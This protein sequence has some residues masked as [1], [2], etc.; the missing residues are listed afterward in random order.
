[1]TLH[2]LKYSPEKL[3]GFIEE[4]HRRMQEDQ[5]FVGSQAF[6]KAINEFT[7]FLLSQA[8]AGTGPGFEALS[9]GDGILVINTDGICPGTS[10]STGFLLRDGVA[11]MYGP[12]PG[13]KRCP[14]CRY[15]ITGPAHLLGQVT[16]AN[17][18]AYSIRKKGLE[19]ARLNELKLDAED[20]GNQ[21]LARELRDRVDLLNREIELDVA[22]WTARYKYVVQSHAQMDDYLKEKAN[23]IA[24]DATPRVP[25]MTSSTPLDLKVTLEQAHEFALLDQITQTAVFNPGF[26]NLQAEL[27]KNH[28][29][30]KMMVANGMKPF[31]LSLSDEQAREAGNLLSALVLQ[32]VNAQDLDEVLTGKMPLEHYPFLSLAMHKLE[33][34]SANDHS[35]LPNALSALS[36][37]IDPSVQPHTDQDDEEL[38]G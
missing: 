11:P 24:T 34:A 15:W 28:V 27:E 4:A 16:A 7:P 38:F 8:G 21:P 37:L 25:T 32:Q 9:S 33:E 35:F 5:D 13:G 23:I 29:L 20:S 17:N 31:L 22:E 26:P 2:Y 36:K 6:I 12:V 10:C 1:M 3:R 18:L 19:L 14:L 30:S